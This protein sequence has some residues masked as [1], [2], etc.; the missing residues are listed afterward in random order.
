V[1]AFLGEKRG[2]AE[3]RP[4]LLDDA[5]T[6]SGG[7]VGGV[8]AKPNVHL[9]AGMRADDATYRICRRL[10][11]IA[12]ANLPGTLDDIDT[13]FLHDLR[14]A[15]RRTRSVLREMRG[16]LEPA[17]R[18]RARTDL[19]WIQEITGPTRD[20]D[21]LLLDWPSVIA[22]L[23]ASTGADLA[24]LHDLLARHRARA[25]RTMC[26]TLRGPQYAVAWS[27]WREL[28][29]RPQ[30]RDAADAP[31]NADRTVAAVAGERIV[32]V[33]RAMVAGGLAIDD[34]S[35]PVALHDLR[36]RGKELRYL[37]ELF[38]SLWPSATVG[39]LVSTLKALQDVL[40]RFQDDEVQA[41]FLRSLGPELA[42]TR[43]GPDAL[44]AVGTL[45]H[46]LADDQA[47]AR[48]AFAARFEPFAAKPTRKLVMATFRP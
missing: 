5:V 2:L 17:A 30:P 34:A 11:D 43:G 31:P 18:E 36:K 38:G 12:E 47:A 1:V 6:Q 42:R 39:P 14:V 45:V 33:Y 28:L 3:A 48:R 37:L 40:G 19:R 27:A 13:E 29:A 7:I 24:P 23:P 8:S 15:V 4:S 20:L 44:V 9:T 16:V 32:A 10:A 22:S 41:T 35:P 46:R 25:W 21:V 26:D